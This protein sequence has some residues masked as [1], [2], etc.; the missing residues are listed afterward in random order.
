VPWGEGDTPVKQVLQLL[1]DK[2]YPMRAF[3]EYEYRGAQ[4]SV[5]EVK[6]YFQYCKD[7]LA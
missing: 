3:I 7:A 6:K 1:R 4:D 2:K 5:A